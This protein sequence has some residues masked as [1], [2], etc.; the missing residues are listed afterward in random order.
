MVK[1][2]KLFAKEKLQSQAKKKLQRQK[3][4]EHLQ[5]QAFQKNASLD[6]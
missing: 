3:E 4:V 2:I 6:A 5:C 1:L